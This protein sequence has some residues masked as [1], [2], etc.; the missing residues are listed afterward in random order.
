MKIVISIATLFLLAGCGTPYGKISAF[1]PNGY[2]ESIL[3]DRRAIVTFVSYRHDRNSSV[4]DGALL[5]SAELAKEK[6]FEGFRII[7]DANGSET[8]AMN[9]G[10]TYSGYQ[11]GGQSFGSVTAM[12]FILSKSQQ[13]LSIYFVTKNELIDGDFVASKIIE[14]M[15]KKF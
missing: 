11:V 3:D 2:S 13:S 14:N 4:I 9:L 10:G 12:P 15:R 1:S 5:R 7:K 6:G 8:T